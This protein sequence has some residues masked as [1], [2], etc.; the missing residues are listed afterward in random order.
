MFL[1]RSLKHVH[2]YP[3]ICSGVSTS[4][5]GGHGMNQISADSELTLHVFSLRTRPD[6]N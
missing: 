5:L 6:T 1:P 4:L 3:F 2:A